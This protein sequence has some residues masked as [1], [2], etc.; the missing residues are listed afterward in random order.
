MESLLDEEGLQV[1]TVTLGELHTAILTTDGE[2]SSNILNLRNFT[3][4]V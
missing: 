1:K 3:P 4:L 2:V